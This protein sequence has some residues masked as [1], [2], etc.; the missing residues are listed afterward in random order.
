MGVPVSG[1]S[2]YAR[3]DSGTAGNNAINPDAGT[4][5]IQ[6]TND[7]PDIP[8]VDTSGDLILNFGAQDPNTSVVYNGIS[9]TMGFPTT[10]L[11]HLS[12]ICWEAIRR[13]QTWTR[14]C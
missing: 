9:Y 10:L 11:S 1:T 2:Y 8:G 14:H 4:I 5:I 6:F 13:A 3:N 7:D 12:A